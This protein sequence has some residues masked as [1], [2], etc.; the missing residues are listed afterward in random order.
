M[1]LALCLVTLLQKGCGMYFILIPLRRA[2]RTVLQQLVLESIPSSHESCGEH[3][4]I[5]RTVIQGQA[6]IIMPFDNFNRW[7]ELSSRLNNVQL[8]IP[9]RSMRISRAITFRVDSVQSNSC[10]C[11]FS[12]AANVRSHSLAISVLEF[13]EPFSGFSTKAEKPNVNSVSFSNDSLGLVC[14]RCYPKRW[15]FHEPA[16]TTYS[17]L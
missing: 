12:S 17:M 1:A 14:A 7:T 4:I 3:L 5:P 15:K 10:K 6:V 8:M 16:G 2:L 13:Y 9:L 11:L